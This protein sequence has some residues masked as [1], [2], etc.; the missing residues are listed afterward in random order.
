MHHAYTRRAR[1]CTHTPMLALCAYRVA[2]VFFSFAGGRQQMMS[3]HEW[4]CWLARYE[5]T[6][7]PLGTPTQS[8][9]YLLIVF[10]S[11]PLQPSSSFVL[12][13]CWRAACKP[14]QAIRHTPVG[15]LSH[16]PNPYM[17]SSCNPYIMAAHFCVPAQPTRGLFR[18]SRP[19]PFG[20][21]D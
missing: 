6:T 9:N 11:F 3:M 17:S 13:D 10:R 20:L 16:P 14:P 12:A 15:A 1:I 19:L 7:R 4:A 18:K 2:L 8:H 21:S 5:H